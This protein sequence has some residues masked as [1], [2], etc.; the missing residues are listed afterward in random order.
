MA[1]GLLRGIWALS[2]ATSAASFVVPVFRHAGG[3]ARGAPLSRSMARGIGSGLSSPWDVVSAIPSRSLSSLK[4]TSVGSTTTSTAPDSDVKPWKIN[5]LY[6][7]KCSLCMKEVTFLQKRDV[8]GNILFTDL[9]DPN[10][11]AEE[12]GGVDY[13]AGMK[14]IHAV[15]PDGEVV[16]GVEVFRRVYEV[17][18]LGWVYAAT[19]IPFIGAAAD[20]AYDQWAIRRLQITGRP[21]LEV[22][23]KQRQE[24]LKKKDF[25][26]DDEGECEIDWDKL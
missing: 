24:E 19:K 22:I 12:N 14:Y 7:G 4:A 2:S 8:D 25:S 16:K 10:F 26:C 11:K 17:I 20:W 1:R 9:N 21:D 18:G 6:D 3:V 23:L 15:L 13:E 5:L